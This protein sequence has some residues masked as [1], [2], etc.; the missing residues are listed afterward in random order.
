MIYIILVIY[1]QNFK[2]DK[3]KKIFYKIFKIYELIIINNSG[4]PLLGAILGSNRFREFGGYYEG[5]N[6]INNRIN[7]SDLILFVNDTFLERRNFEGYYLNAYRIFYFLCK[8][9]IIKDLFVIGEM[10][11]IEEKLFNTEL[12][13]KNHISTYFFLTNKKTIEKINIEFM[14]VDIDLSYN[15]EKN[16]FQS[17]LVSKDYIERINR[18]LIK[19]K[20]QKKQWYKT[21]EININN[22]EIL[23]SKAKAIFK[24]HYLTYRCILNNVK[25]IPIYSNNKYSFTRLI[26]YIFNR[27]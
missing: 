20:N 9:N 21:E 13:I 25:L 12:K 1:D 26:M 10:H 3:Y 15:F 7:D 2:I 16:T 14:N 27:L 19:D 17:R 8:I 18:W 24:E 5:Y 6:K 4:K 22:V 11:S 23:V